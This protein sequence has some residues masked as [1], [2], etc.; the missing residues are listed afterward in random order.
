MEARAFT[1]EPGEG[2]KAIHPLSP[3]SIVVL[4][5]VIH[6]AGSAYAQQPPLGGTRVE[7]TTLDAKSAPENVFGFLY[8]P[9]SPDTAKR[10]PAMVVVHSSGGARDTRE[11]DYGRRLSES[12][13]AVLA[14]DAFS[15]RGI[16]STVEDQSRIATAQIVRDAFAAFAYLSK[17]SSIDPTRVG[18]MGMSLGGSV[19]IQAAD[20]REEATARKRM[21]VGNF[22]VHVSL[23]PSCSTQY[24]NPRMIAPMLVLIGADDDYTG[25]KQCAAYLERIRAAGGKAEL[26]TFPG[27]VHGFD[28]D[29][30]T[31]RHFYVSTAQNFREC[32]FYIEDDGRI[33]T[34]AG[35]LIDLSAP[36]AAIEIARRECMKQGATVGA[37]AAAKA[38]ALADIKAFLK[39]H[40]M[41]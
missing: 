9:K 24:R 21:E 3:I 4:C 28:G 39:T 23:Y 36:A 30:S 14:I 11:G 7:Y 19:A 16:R 10:V 41:N 13:I 12:G 22:A 32:T 27:A 37:D 1:G 34:Q 2:G 20:V 40:L 6:I 8:L 29:T 38:Q 25:V 17:H 31:R 33:V 5:A 26:K 18:V 35:T 15:P